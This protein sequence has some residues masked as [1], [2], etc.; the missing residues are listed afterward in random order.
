MF[1]RFYENKRNAVRQAVSK[2]NGD[3]QLQNGDH[4]KSP[5]MGDLLAR[6]KIGDLITGDLKTGDLIVGQNPAITTER[7]KWAISALGDHPFR[8]LF[9]LE[10]LL[11]PRNNYTIITVLR[12][13]P[14]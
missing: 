13:Q 14:K 10:G 3:L 2:E 5:K 8:E 1:A 12:R 9:F 4:Q 11:L 6:H 7:W